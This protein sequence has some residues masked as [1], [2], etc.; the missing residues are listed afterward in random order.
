M[1]HLVIDL[2]S[3]NGKIYLVHLDANKKI[4]FN[5]VERFQVERLFFRGHVCTNL[6]AIYDKICNTI[7][8]LIRKGASIDTL[9][10]DSWCSDYGII[11][12]AEGTVSI[13]VF[14]RDHRTD[15]VPSEIEHIMDYKEIYW[16][17][18]QRKIPDSTLCQL[19][20]YKKEYPKGLEG[21]KKLLFLGDLLMYLFT[22]N[23]CSEISV[24]SYSQMFS[25]KNECWE[26][27]ILNKFGIPKEIC[28]PVAKPGTILGEIQKPL[29]DFLGVKNV[30]V[31]VPAVHD[32]ASAAVAVPAKPGEKWAFLATGIQ[33]W[34]LEKFC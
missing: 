1:Q 9:G 14:Y 5:E 21:D 33:A 23:L 16:L 10:I 25:I 30:K 13:P 32:T 18:T 7:V 8:Q 4:M 24:A 34:H 15:G 26:D 31:V 11:D 6:P 28:P 27:E 17:T 3:S 29:A 2:G 22:G 12:K 19:I 20:A